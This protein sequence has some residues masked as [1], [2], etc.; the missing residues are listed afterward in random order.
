MAGSLRMVVCLA[1]VGGELSGMAVR[2]LW[3]RCSRRG[4]LGRCLADL[5]ENGKV[6]L[7]GEGRLD[8]RVLRLTED[9]R[10][11]AQGGI[12]PPSRWSRRWDRRWRIVAFDIPES[13]TALRTRLRR[14][15]H[16]FRFGWL[17]NSVWISPDPIDAFR[18]G[19]NEKTT[20]P[21]SLTFLEA[22]TVGGESSEAMVAAA[23]DFPALAKSHAGYLDV[24]RLRPGAR[25]PF[26]S[27]AN[28]VG[29]EQRA[30]RRVSRLDPFLPRELL[31]DGY[32]GEQVWAARREAF[33]EF[34]SVLAK[35][36]AV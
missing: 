11:E 21:D 35:V 32:V 36:L 17:Q 2:L 10:G 4:R 14:R 22:A 19:L 12:D 9:G 29:T 26:E 31:P 30:W 20:F 15:L 18:A 24:L 16:E 8:R 23:W 34:G 27:W 6:R 13:A 7:V 3:E 28:W 1:A 5:E 33:A 25:R